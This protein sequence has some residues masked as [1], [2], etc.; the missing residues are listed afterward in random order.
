MCLVNGGR[1]LV[2]G[3]QDGSL[4]IFAWD[5]W[6]APANRFLTHPSSVDTMRGI[7]STD[8]LVVTGGGDGLI[9]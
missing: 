3:M 1:Q 4:N 7:K 8:G 6:A 5:Q 2:C 9:R